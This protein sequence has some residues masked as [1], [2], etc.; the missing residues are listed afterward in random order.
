MKMNLS[1]IF[2]LLCFMCCL[3]ACTS[4]GHKK[5][6]LKLF[7]IN[8]GSASR[9]D[10]E[11]AVKDCGGSLKEHT[12]FYNTYDSTN[13]LDG[14]KELTLLFNKNYDFAGAEYTFPAFND[15]KKIEKVR[16]MVEAKYG[17]PSSSQGF[18][19]VG[20][21]TYK[22]KLNGGFLITVERGWP[23]TSVSLSF[24][25]EKKFDEAISQIEKM[26]KE[27]QKAALKKQENSF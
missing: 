15:V 8:V 1:K 9:E 25:H 2:V 14:S 6:E 24:C 10:I 3:T 22:W 17:T 26:K 5:N 12:F 4:S 19:R 18:P 7:G 20:P 16:E 23:N 13:L 27:A 11:K 21:V